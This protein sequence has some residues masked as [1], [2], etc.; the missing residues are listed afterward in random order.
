MTTRRGEAGLTLIEVVVSLAIFAII[1]LAGLALL[2]T[3]ARTGDRTEGRLDRL[4]E[5]DRTFLV[6]RR[7]LAQI[8]PQ[9]VTL[10]GGALTFARADGDGTATLTYLLDDGALIRQIEA[11]PV[12]S[13]QLL[14]DITDMRWRLMDRARTWHDSWPPQ[15]IGPEARPAAAE[16]YLEAVRVD[17]PG[18]PPAGVTRLIAL[19]AGQ[20]L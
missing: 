13:Q 19:P 1:G 7:D 15:G 20:G 9:P 2:N 3:V 4:S 10:E 14:S 5:I 12:L 8:A 16:L 6:I 11:A 17:Q 18:L